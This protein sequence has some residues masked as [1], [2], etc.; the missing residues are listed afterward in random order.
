MLGSMVTVGKRSGLPLP[1]TAV[2]GAERSRPR[3]VLVLMFRSKIELTPPIGWLESLGVT[4]RIWM[5]EWSIVLA[6]PAPWMSVWI[7][8]VVVLPGTTL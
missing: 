7:D 4:S 8:W 1:S 6:V 5:S 3:T 2:C